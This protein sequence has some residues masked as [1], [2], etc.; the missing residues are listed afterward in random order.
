MHE[1]DQL[2]NLTLDNFLVASILLA[3]RRR[4]L[5]SCATSNTMQHVTETR[6]D[7]RRDVRLG[8]TTTVRTSCDCV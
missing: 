4:F 1:G 6:P 7:H 2:V 5:L 8:M 3:A